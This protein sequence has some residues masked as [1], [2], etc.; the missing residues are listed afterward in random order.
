MF[1][2]FGNDVKFEP[3]FIYYGAGTTDCETTGYNTA[4]FSGIACA[5][6]IG[7]VTTGATVNLEAEMSTA[8]GGTYVGIAD[9]ASYFSST[10]GSSGLWLVTSVY[11]PMKQYVKFVADR[12]T[13]NT[14]IMGSIVMLYRAGDLPVSASTRTNAGYGANIQDYTDVVGS[15]GSST[16]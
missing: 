7:D 9:S 2:N 4:G 15:S 12:H 6:L 3:G 1:R 11:K 13:G 10:Q 8:A 5:L 14:Q 16:G